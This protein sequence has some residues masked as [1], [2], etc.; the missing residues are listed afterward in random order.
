MRWGPSEGN[1]GAI[2]R[3]G[4]HLDNGVWF[5]W[6]HWRS[7][8]MLLRLRVMRKY[9]AVSLLCIH[10]GQSKEVQCN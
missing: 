3:W 2:V 10:W 5:A 7:K 1:S 8:R 9:I 6:R 4:K